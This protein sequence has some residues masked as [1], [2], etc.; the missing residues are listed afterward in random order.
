VRPGG[1]P[2][3]PSQ[4]RASTGVERV[5]EQAVLFEAIAAA[6]GGHELGED[7]RA[8]DRDAA[9]EDHVEIFERDCQSVR[10]LE[11]RQPFRGRGRRLLEADA[12]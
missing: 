3:R 11:L 6:P 1:G 10:A 2:S 9:A 4:T 5:A 8:V 7:G 12:F